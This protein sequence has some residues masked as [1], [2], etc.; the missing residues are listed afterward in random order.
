MKIISVDGIVVSNTAFKENSKIINIFTKDMGIIGAVSK[1]CKK[2]SSKLRLP[3]ERFAYGT[4]HL[5]YNENG[6][7]TLVDGDIKNYFITI[8]SD[9]LKIS[10]LTYI[11]DLAINVYK[12]SLDNQVYNLMEAAILK[13][14]EGMDAKIITNI[15]ELQYLEYLGIDLNLD[16]CV[17]C[18]STKVVTLSLSKGGYVCQN[19]R[20]NEILIDEK[21]L[22]MLRLYYYVDI[23]KINELNI[24]KKISDE[25]D[26]IINEYYEEYSGIYMKSKKML[27]TLES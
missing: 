10:Y 12:E 6:L 22:K 20:T 3:S 2:M 9:I 14:E 26:N 5:Y 19:C 17:K 4:F 16:S 11:C 1:G 15:L 23:S 24:D 21:V 27:K 25:I 7:S 8:T 13:I 18:G